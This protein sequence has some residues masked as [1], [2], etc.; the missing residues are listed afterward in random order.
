MLTFNR[1]C[2]RVRA[3][4][5][6]IYGCN[7]L[8]RNVLQ[9]LELSL[10]DLGVD[11][12]IVNHIPLLERQWVKADQI[13]DL[14]KDAM[15]KAG[16]ACSSSDT[17]AEPGLTLERFEIRMKALAHNEGWGSRAENPKINMGATRQGYYPFQEVVF[18]IT[19]LGLSYGKLRWTKVW[20]GNYYH[21]PLAQSYI[22]L[23]FLLSTVRK[24][25]GELSPA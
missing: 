3:F 23:E 19:E 22:S 7:L 14:A 6:D 9:E 12:G 20:S 21:N 16:I 8:D 10:T 2:N 25:L 17:L 18:S 4:C 13:I 11:R 15:A 24:M 5:Q 1:F